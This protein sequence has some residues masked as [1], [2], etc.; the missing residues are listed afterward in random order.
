[1]V[2]L[3][4]EAFAELAPTL[5]HA[6]RAFCSPRI[7]ICRPRLAHR[8]R[9]ARATTDGR[10]RHRYMAR[11]I[12]EACAR[13]SAGRLDEHCTRVMQRRKRPT[14]GCRWTPGDRPAG[15]PNS[16]MPRNADQAIA[17]AEQDRDGTIAR[18]LM[19]TASG[20][21]CRALCAA[22][23]RERG[24][25]RWRGSILPVTGTPSRS[26][27]VRVATRMGRRR[28]CKPRDRAPRSAEHCRRG[29]G[30]MPD[31]MP[32]L[33][34]DLYALPGMDGTAARDTT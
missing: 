1:M 12:L 21:C 17:V 20:R 5:A 16:S 23:W 22:A 19:S 34:G 9:A 6:E 30:C 7:S 33:P 13:R 29:C 10:A 3:T 27:L 24:R 31:A 28:R 2:V 4:M 18:L 15:G 26:L 8:G 11:R 32:W 25:S 14:T